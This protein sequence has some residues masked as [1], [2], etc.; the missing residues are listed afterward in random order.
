ML[1][2]CQHSLS[3]DPATGYEFTV[4]IRKIR[5]TRH[6]HGFKDGVLASHVNEK[7]KSK[8]EGQIHKDKHSPKGGLCRSGA[9]DTSE[10]CLDLS[11][12]R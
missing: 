6:V 10:A 7:R 5:D 12:T 2:A 8:S 3:N 1:A 11:A 9:T 4:A